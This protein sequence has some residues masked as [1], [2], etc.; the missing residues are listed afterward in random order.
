MGSKKRKPLIR[1]MINTLF[2]IMIVSIGYIGY[3]IIFDLRVRFINNSALN[4]LGEINKEYAARFK[5]F[6]DD[7]EKE[8]GWKVEI[9]SGLRS[10]EEQI[11]LKRDNPQN[12]AVNKSRH[13]LG[14]AIDINLYKREG[15]FTLRLK[16]FSPKASWQKTGIP[17][18]AKRYRLLWG[19]TY[20][21]YHDPVHFEIN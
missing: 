10:K 16:K 15:I 20:R 2:V 8:T 19:G 18:I 17:E 5:S 12:A 9:I 21:N 14:R 13:V 1:K 3:T 7:T 4:E 6:I 11:Q